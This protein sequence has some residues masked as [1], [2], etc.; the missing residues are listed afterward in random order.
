MIFRKDNKDKDNE[1]TDIGLR[2]VKILLLR[3]YTMVSTIPLK[4]YEILIAVIMGVLLGLGVGSMISGY[5]KVYMQL[6]LL[7]R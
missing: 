2:L 5:V 3:L 7:H 1:N 4:W 6:S